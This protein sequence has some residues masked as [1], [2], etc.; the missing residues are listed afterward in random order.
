M[1]A[2]KTY[3]LNVALGGTAA[4]LETLVRAYRRCQRVDELKRAAAAAR[5]APPEVLP[6]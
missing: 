2:T 1:R 6:R 4:H 3:L 5:P